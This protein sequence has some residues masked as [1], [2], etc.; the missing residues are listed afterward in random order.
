MSATDTLIDIIEFDVEKIRKDFPILH[1]QINNKPLVYFDNA[2]TT[3]KP[4]VVIDALVHYYTTMNA[5]IHRGIHTLAERSTSAFEDTRKTVKNFLNASSSDE[6]IFTKGTTEGINL[7]AF[8]FGAAFIKAGDEILISAMEHHSDIVPWH[9]VAEAK[10][11]KVRIIP[12]DDSGDIIFEEFERLI[13]EKTKIVSIVHASNTLGTI[14]P[15]EEIIKVAHRNGAKVLIDGSQSSSHI[16]IDV[17]KLDCDFFVLSSH[18]LYGPTGVGILYG[19]R[20]LLD[21]MPPY[22]GGGEMIKEVTY[23]KTTYNDLPYKFEAGT[24]NIADV[25][26]FKYA[27]D[28]VQALGKKNIAAYENELLEYGT[29]VLS[30]IPGFQIIGQAKKKV[31]I[32][33]FVVE[34]IKSTLDIGM[35]LDT[36]GIA[37]RTGHHCTMPLMERLCIEGT[38][39]ASFAFYNTKEEIDRLAIGIQK[40]IKLFS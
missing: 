24:P 8:S 1:Q 18:K 34:S 40:A 12:I 10:G 4:Q 38:A 3:Q 2:A 13:S 39:R 28:Y 6:I 31:S 22:Q 36:Q 21:A 19:K 17:Q 35:Y 30:S 26:A 15:I 7:V 29:E 16:D 27:I 37:V 5:N 32:I 25:I 9:I 11:A 20:V 33:S 23:E 14:N